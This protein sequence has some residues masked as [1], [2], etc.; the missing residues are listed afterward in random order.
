[1][2]QLMNFMGL[3]I[4]PFKGGGQG[5][6]SSLVL[7]GRKCYTRELVL[8]QARDMW[9]LSLLSCYS[10]LIVN[11]AIMIIKNHI[12]DWWIFCSVHEPYF[13]VLENRQSIQ[14]NKRQ[15]KETLWFPHRFFAYTYLSKHEIF[16]SYKKPRK[17]F[18]FF[19]FL[20]QSSCVKS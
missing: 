5:S 9:L 19:S 14:S 16:H 4:F 15:K 7:K 17:F 10:F 20:A 1:M 3:S 18:I 12:I 6:P 8:Q 11:C 2:E 13:L